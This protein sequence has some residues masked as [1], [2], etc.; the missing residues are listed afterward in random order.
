MIPTVI[1]LVWLRPWCENSDLTLTFDSPGYA[2]G[3]V[4]RS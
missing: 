2:P 4:K 3:E 1:G